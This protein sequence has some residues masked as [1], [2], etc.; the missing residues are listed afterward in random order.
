MIY[1]YSDLNLNKTPVRVLPQKSPQKTKKCHHDWPR[2]VSKCF[3][4]KKLASI[5]RSTQFCAQRSSDESR[6]FDVIFPPAMHFFQQ[7]SER[8]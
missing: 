8:L 7:I 5:H 4:I 2:N 3:R 6:R 1:S